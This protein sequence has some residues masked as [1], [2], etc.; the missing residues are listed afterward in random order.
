[1]AAGRKQVGLSEFD[2]LIW[3]YIRDAGGWHSQREIASALA[4]DAT[5]RM[6]LRHSLRRLERD[7]HL[8]N[9]PTMAG[10]NAWGCTARCDAP[11]GLSLDPDE[12]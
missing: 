4:L 2:R 11:T 8:V 3:R 7:Y 1:M 9:R 12:F 6:K 10:D 5:Q